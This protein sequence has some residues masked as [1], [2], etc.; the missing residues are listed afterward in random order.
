MWLRQARKM[1]DME[2]F[3]TASRGAFG[4]LLLLINLGPKRPHWIAALGAFLTIMAAFTG[5]ATQQLLIFNECLQRDS[6]AQVGIAKSNSYFRAAPRIGAGAFHVSEEMASAIEIGI[7][8]PNQDQTQ[9]LSH[10]CITGNCTFPA[11]SGASYSTL[12]IG[13]TCKDV[14]AEVYTVPT[15]ITYSDLQGKSHQAFWANLTAPSG[16]NDSFSATG[17]QIGASPFTFSTRAYSDP[18]YGSIAIVQM[19]L[20]HGLG[21]NNYTAH[22][23]SVFPIVNGYEVRITKTV[24]RERLLESVSAGVNMISEV[25]KTVDERQIQFKRASNTLF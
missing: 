6:S 9:L 2:R 22:S 1:D 20:T 23:C 5:F 21:Q 19:I 24:L 14:T 7:I 4:S 25:N 13:H 12:A 10:G 17:L 11:A 18:T 8:Q 16:K 15:N 3:D